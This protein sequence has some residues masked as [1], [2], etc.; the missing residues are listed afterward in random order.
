[1]EKALTGSG[2]KHIEIQI[3]G[4]G[5]GAVNYLWERENAVFRDGKQLSLSRYVYS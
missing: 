4:D 3:I 1:V 2:W 5:T